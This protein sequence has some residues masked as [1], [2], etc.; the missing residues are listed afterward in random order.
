MKKI[1]IAAFA[2]LMITFSACESKT[3]MG[4]SDSGYTASEQ[5]N[6]DAF[7]AVN[8]AFE[9]G[10]TSSLDSIVASDFV[11]HTDQGDK[12]GIDSVKSMVTHM[13]AMMSNMKMKEVNVTANG[14]YVYGWMQYAGNS[15]GSMGMPPGPFDMQSVEVVKFNNE[16]K[17]VEHWGF[18]ESQ[19]VMEMMQKMGPGMGAPKDSVMNK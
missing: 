1:T 12:K 11:D 10:E 9:T 19:D 14:D 3:E 16:N 15:D 7:R 6:I 5:K 18:L 8:K 13:H 17:A 2:A 4:T